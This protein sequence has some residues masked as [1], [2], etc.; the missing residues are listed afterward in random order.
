MSVQRRPDPDGSPRGA[1]L[2]ATREELLRRGRPF[3]AHEDMVI[4]ELS[5]EEAEAFWAEITQA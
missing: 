3:P 2:E 5:D 4:E 1:S